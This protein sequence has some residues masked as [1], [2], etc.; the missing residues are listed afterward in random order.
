MCPNLSSSWN[1]VDMQVISTYNVYVLVHVPVYKMYNRIDNYKIKNQGLTLGLLP[2]KFIQSDGMCSTW[3]THL[4]DLKS[5]H[6]WFQLDQDTCEPVILLNCLSPY[7]IE[8]TTIIAHFDE[9][10]MQSIVITLCL[11]DFHI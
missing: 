7:S 11:L 2:G 4:S 8:H 9:R 3:S 10:P 1:D 6:L 5:N